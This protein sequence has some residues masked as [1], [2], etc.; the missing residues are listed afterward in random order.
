MFKEN[1]E[2]PKFGSKGKLTKFSGLRMRSPGRIFSLFKYGIIFS[3]LWLFAYVYVSL[4]KSELLKEFK[5]EDMN[6]DKLQ[7]K[8]SDLMRGFNQGNQQQ[9]DRIVMQEFK[10]EKYELDDGITPEAR[11]FMKEL[12]LQNPGEDGVPVELPANLSD[13][14]Q[15]RIKEGYDNHGYNAFVSSM[16]SLNRHIPDIRS[17]VCKAKNYTNLPKCS[18]LIPFHNEDWMLLMRTV[19]SVLARSPLEL[20]E[21]ILLV[22]DASDRGGCLD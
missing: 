21:E 20:I 15:R 6:I 22:D 17:D 7:A 8:I 13:D 2:D 5:K 3:V 19:H 12:G 18:I 1:S 4:Y 11:Q 10:E 9:I 14:I 16:V